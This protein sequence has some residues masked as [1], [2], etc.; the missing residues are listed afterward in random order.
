M[1]GPTFAAHN[2]AIIGKID[3]EEE[4][5]GNKSDDRPGKRPAR[6]TKMGFSLFIGKV[7]ES[8]NCRLIWM[9]PVNI[10]DALFC[11]TSFLMMKDYSQAAGIQQGVSR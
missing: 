1:S 6:S 10:I 7:H 8:Q 2:I 3:L 5:S 9:G 11:E 4:S